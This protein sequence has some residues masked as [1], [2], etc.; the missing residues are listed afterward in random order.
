MKKVLKTIVK[1][2]KSFWAATKKTFS[3]FIATF[4]GKKKGVVVTVSTTYSKD[5]TTP[6][7]IIFESPD[8]ATTQERGVI[9]DPFQKKPK[10]TPRKRKTKTLRRRA[11]K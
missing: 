1:K 3:D 4:R 2:L 6:N 11:R 9:F 8:P 5:D 7:V 10:I